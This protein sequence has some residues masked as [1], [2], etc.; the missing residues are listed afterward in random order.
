MIQDRKEVYAPLVEIGDKVP[1]RIAT[2][3]PER[4]DAK[5]TVSLAW[6]DILYRDVVYIK[7]YGHEVFVSAADALKAMEGGPAINWPIA[8]PMD[9]K[10]R[11]GRRNHRDRNRRAK[12]RSP[13]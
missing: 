3:D 12:N 9:D 11:R 13:R 2:G 1:I 7:Y 4:R 5:A 10:T 6:P 8:V